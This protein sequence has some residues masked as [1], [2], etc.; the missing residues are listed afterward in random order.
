MPGL[1]PSPL[2]HFL[3]VMFCPFQFWLGLTTQELWDSLPELHP[4]PD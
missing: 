1:G 3:R 4:G 2:V